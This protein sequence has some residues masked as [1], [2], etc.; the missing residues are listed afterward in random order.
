MKQLDLH[1]QGQLSRSQ[2]VRAA[3]QDFLD[4]PEKAKVAIDE[5]YEAE[6]EIATKYGLQN[7]NLLMCFNAQG[8]HPHLYG[9]AL[10]YPKPVEVVRD[11]CGFRA[12]AAQQPLVEDSLG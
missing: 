9:L 7:K 10:R 4:R 5:V 3:I 1:A 2:I 11:C 6:R 12:V 8:K